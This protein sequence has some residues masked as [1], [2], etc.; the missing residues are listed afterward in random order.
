MT[1]GEEGCA[2]DGFDCSDEWHAAI[3]D[4]AQATV[5]ATRSMARSL[6]GLRSPLMRV[7]AYAARSQRGLPTV[8][9]CRHAID[10]GTSVVFCWYP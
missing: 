4:A 10:R 1:T 6:V 5:N 8:S 9:L 3:S 2:G 7:R